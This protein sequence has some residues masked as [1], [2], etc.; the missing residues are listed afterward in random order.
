MVAI[1]AFGGHV[2]HIIW[3]SKLTP[4]PVGDPLAKTATDLRGEP[5]EIVLP[6]LLET[7]MS[8]IPRRHHHSF[9][10][11]FELALLG[12]MEEAFPCIPKTIR[13]F[14]RITVLFVPDILFRPKPPLLAHCKDQF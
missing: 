12:K 5:G 3:I 13:P 6:Q 11:H 14:A 9:L 8:P 2:E 7:L 4:N 10:E 1:I